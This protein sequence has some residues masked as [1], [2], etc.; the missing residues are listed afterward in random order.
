[1]ILWTP[2]MKAAPVCLQ[3]SAPRVRFRGVA[4]FLA[5]K[6]KSIFK[7]PF[8]S[9]HYKMNSYKI[10]DIS[11]P[12]LPCMILSI[13]TSCHL[14]SQVSIGPNV[15]ENIKSLFQ[16]SFFWRTKNRKQVVNHVQVFQHRASTVQHHVLLSC[17]SARH[18]PSAVVLNAG[19]VHCLSITGESQKHETDMAVNNTTQLIFQI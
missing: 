7:G 17:L 6:G 13:N 18:C 15:S 5:L 8:W 12:T 19:Q 10:A 3:A 11:Y 4:R 9:T 14:L 2:S 16:T 1:M